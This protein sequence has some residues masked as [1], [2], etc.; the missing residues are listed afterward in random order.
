MKYIEPN[1]DLRCTVTGV[2]NAAD[3]SYLNSAAVAVRV[4][5][6]GGTVVVSAQTVNYIAASNGNFA[7]TADKALFASLTKGLQYN[8]YF[9][10][11]DSGTSLDREIK[12]IAV[13]DHDPV[14]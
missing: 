12:L 13:Y 1:S 14:I 9:T 11:T 7:V 5:S 6:A 8:V 3:D 10:I 4:E 2:Q